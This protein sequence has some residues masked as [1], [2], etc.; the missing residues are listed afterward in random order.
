[1]KNDTE[2]VSRLKGMDT[3]CMQ[4]LVSSA[5]CIGTFGMFEMVSECTLRAQICILPY[6][7]KL[8]S[9]F[10]SDFVK[11]HITLIP[12]FSC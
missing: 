10:R 11:G 5:I 8:S 2:V 6:K 3:N 12:W 4:G 9:K 1:M 7:V